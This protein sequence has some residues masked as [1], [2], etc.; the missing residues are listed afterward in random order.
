TIAEL[1]HEDPDT[2]DRM[3]AHLSDLLRR[4]LDLGTLQQV[5]LTAEIDLVSRYLDIQR[6]RF[7]ERLHVTIDVDPGAARGFVP[8]L[9]LQP[10]VENA[11]RHGLGARLNAGRISIDARVADRSLV[12]AVTDDGEGAPAAGVERVGLGNT[13]ARLDALYG[14]RARLELS[15]SDG[16][17]T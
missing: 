11:I 17:G 9:L 14:A 13:R 1:V 7:G 2:A 4:T 15:S 6:A 16:R 3:I 12:I 5:P 10:L 8:P